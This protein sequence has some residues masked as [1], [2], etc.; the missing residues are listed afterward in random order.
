MEKD[1]YWFT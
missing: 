1:S